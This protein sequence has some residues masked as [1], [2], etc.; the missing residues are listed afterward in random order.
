VLVEQGVLVGEMRVVDFRLELAVMLEVVVVVE[1]PWSL[2]VVEVGLETL[3]V[4]MR[5]GVDLEAVVGVSAVGAVVDHLV[6]VG[7][8]VVAD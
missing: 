6:V 2:P 8:E 5:L 3:A 4:V 7:L 1:Q